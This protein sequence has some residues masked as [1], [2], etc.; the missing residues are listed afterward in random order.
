MDQASST[1]RLRAWLGELWSPSVAIIA[2]PEADALCQA[3][4]GLSVVSLLRP[5]GVLPQLNGTIGGE[6]AQACGSARPA[7]AVAAPV[8]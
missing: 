5:F 4:N 3:A 2:S 6:G 1:A 7:G 8:C